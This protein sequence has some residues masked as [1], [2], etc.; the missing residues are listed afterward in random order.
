MLCQNFKTFIVLSFCNHILPTNDDICHIVPSHIEIAYNSNF[1]L[2]FLLLALL[3][4][5]NSYV[6]NQ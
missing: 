4:F 1:F 2:R 5:S 3:S 6:F